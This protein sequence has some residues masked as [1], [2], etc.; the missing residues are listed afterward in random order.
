M[1]EY[2]I[3]IENV[4]FR[5]FDNA[6][7]IDILPSDIHFV[8]RR[9][10]NTLEVLHTHPYY[11]V[12][13]CRDKPYS[14]GF[15]NFT[16]TVYPGDI[17][18]VPPG[19]EHTQ[20]SDGGAGGDRQFFHFIIL[21]KNGG[22]KNLFAFLDS[23]LAKPGPILISDAPDAA[24]RT[25]KL[26]SDTRRDDD[27]GFLAVTAAELIIGLSRLPSKVLSTENFKAD[28][29]TGRRTVDMELSSEIENLI[30]SRFMTDITSSQAAGMLHLSVRQF[31]RIMK[32]NYGQSFRQ[33]VTLRRLMVAVELFKTTKLSIE[34]V[35]SEV[36]FSSRSGFTKAFELQYG[37]TPS[38]YRKTYC[39]SSN[40]ENK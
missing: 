27:D 28:V 40:G 26:I 17:L 5:V 30:A 19:V 4:F 11:E 23:F 9:K 14:V 38:K 8:C 20:K 34:E 16:Q 25:A 2:N 29:M 7:Y 18:V 10:I 37:M 33:T 39:R 24:E 12:F 35:L 1:H 22:N 3:Q 13:V 6:A 32:K 15:A 21:R 31:D 36:G